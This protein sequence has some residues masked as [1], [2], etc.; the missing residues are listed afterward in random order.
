MELAIA[1]A[2]G[3][4]IGF[5][6][7]RYFKDREINI[8]K[9]NSLNK[10]IQNDEIIK[11]IESTVELSTN[12]AQ[13]PYFDELTKKEQ[14]IALREIWER[15]EQ[16]IADSVVDHYS[17]DEIVLHYLFHQAGILEG[18][19]PSELCMRL[20]D[21]L[22]HRKENRWDRKFANLYQHSPINGRKG[23]EVWGDGHDKDAS[24]LHFC[25][26]QKRLIQHWFVSGPHAGRVE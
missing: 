15:D 22:E 9:N 4:V 1:L 24:F 17:G 25:T 11:T 18:K 7:T 10:E 26:H 20:D 14:R 19:K 2:I 5:F 21:D 8:I 6:I 3:V 16:F 13:K 12:K 23:F